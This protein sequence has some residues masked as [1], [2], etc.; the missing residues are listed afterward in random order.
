[1]AEKRKRR[2]FLGASKG[3][4]NPVGNNETNDKYLIY[5]KHG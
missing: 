3:S 1:M 5:N 4:F 2:R